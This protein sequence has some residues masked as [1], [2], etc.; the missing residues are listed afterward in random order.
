MPI[1]IILYFL[2]NRLRGDEEAFQTLVENKGVLVLI[3]ARIAFCVDSRLSANFS[4][5]QALDS[6][7]S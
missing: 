2:S 3:R 5:F 4:S 6:C 1:F 7:F